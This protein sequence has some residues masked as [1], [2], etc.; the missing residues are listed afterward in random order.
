MKDSI[1]CAINAG[2]KDLLCL[3]D[4]KS[5]IDLITGNTSVT[6]IQVILHDIG[7]M[8]QFLDSISFSFIPLIRNE[9]ADRLAK[10]ALVVSLNSSMV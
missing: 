4:C 1:S 6:S 7:V 5:L 9:A 8:G 3:T 10:A 2:F